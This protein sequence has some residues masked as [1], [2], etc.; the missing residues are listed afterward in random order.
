[1]Y[2]LTAEGKA[3]YWQLMEQGFLVL[4]GVK[5][6]R[7][8][9]PAWQ[10]AL[11]RAG[12]S[13]RYLRPLA[14]GALPS[15]Q[16]FPQIFSKPHP[17]RGIWKSAILQSYPLTKGFVHIYGKPCAGGGFGFPSYGEVPLLTRVLHIPAANHAYEG[18]VRISS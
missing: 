2:F 10:G 17:G 7:A 11:H 5:D 8:V 9:S 14:R 13:G 1:M 3:F 12:S 4:V 16:G 6:G 18:N 15:H